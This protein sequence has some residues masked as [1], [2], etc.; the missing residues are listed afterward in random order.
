M[1]M[2]PND[3]ARQHHDALFPNH[4]STPATTDPELIG[5]AITRRQ[6]P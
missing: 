2:T 5:Q 1:L 4:A 6:E 3:R